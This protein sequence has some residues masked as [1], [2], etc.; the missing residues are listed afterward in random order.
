MRP[1][2]GAQTTNYGG[3]LIFPATGSF[4]QVITIPLFIQQIDIPIRKP[5]LTEVNTIPTHDENS[6]SDWSTQA[7]FYGGQSLLISTMSGYLIT[8][9]VLIA[10]GISGQKYAQLAPTTGLSTDP[11]LGYSYGD[12]V[13]AYLEG[14]LNQP[15]PNVFVRTDPSSY[16]DPFGNVYTN[17]VIQ[18]F[19]CEHAPTVTDQQK[20]T[21]TIYLEV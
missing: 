7:L 8:P 9:V 4:P 13:W 2:Y 10:D 3:Q 6:F 11:L 21:M 14:K 16:T 5:K 12:I 15:N 20:F 18:Q 1:N 19:T 17:P